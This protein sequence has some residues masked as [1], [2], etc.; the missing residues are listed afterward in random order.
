MLAMF[1]YVGPAAFSVVTVMTLIGSRSAPPR[2]PS[3]VASVAVDRAV[4]GIGVGRCRAVGACRRRSASRARRR[5]VVAVPAE[6]SSSR[7]Q[8]DGQTGDREQPAARRHERRVGIE[9][10]SSVVDIMFPQLQISRAP[11]AHRPPTYTTIHPMFETRDRM[12]CVPR[13]SRPCER[14]RTQRYSGSGCERVTTRYGPTCS[15]SM[16]HSERGDRREGDDERSHQIRIAGPR[17]WR[18]VRARLPGPDRHLPRHRRAQLRARR[19]RHRRRVH[20][21]GAAERAR[22]AVPAVGD[23]R[24]RLVGASSARS[25]T[26][27]SCGRCAVR[28]RWFA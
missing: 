17:R 2:S 24:H 14:L 20:A 21:V 4:G 15:S 6:S 3:V 26:G 23:R 25:P 8:A 11:D 22:L 13:R 16:F 27:W 28:A 10:G 19:H 9:R 7:P 1:S 12:E 18:P 5:P